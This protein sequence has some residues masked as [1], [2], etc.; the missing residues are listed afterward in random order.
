MHVFCVCA[1]DPYRLDGCQVDAGM[2]CF[3]NRC[4]WQSHNDMQSRVSNACEICTGQVAAALVQQLCVGASVWHGFIAVG[5]LN[6]Q[7]VL[8]A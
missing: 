4:C 1:Y 7:P 6:Q 8:A 2:R 3:S 5:R